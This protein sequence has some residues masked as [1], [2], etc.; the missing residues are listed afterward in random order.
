MNFEIHLI[1]NQVVFLCMELK[2]KT[3]IETSWEQKELLRWN[4]KHFSSFLK[5]FR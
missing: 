5:G 1:S 3:K 4:E 2:A